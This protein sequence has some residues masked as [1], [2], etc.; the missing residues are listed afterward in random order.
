MPGAARSREG[1][2]RSSHSKYSLILQV[3]V[4]DHS[5]KELH[6][7]NCPSS[8]PRARAGAGHCFG[9]ED[10]KT[11]GTRNEN[12]RVRCSQS[13]PIKQD[14]PARTRSFGK[15]Q[16]PPV[17]R[18]VPWMCCGVLGTRTCPWPPVAWLP[19]Q[20]SP[21]G[22]AQ[23]PG[24]ILQDPGHSTVFPRETEGLHLAAGNERGASKAPQQLGCFSRGG[25]ERGFLPRLPH[26]PSSRGGSSSPR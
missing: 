13:S 26:A 2:R 8:V 17:H 25:V 18:P 6:W 11:M 19:R 1:I 4:T 22:T 3:S 21:A 12:S 5:Q 20:S 15:R 7:P 23:S 10:Q 16:L 9:A 24:R 14:F